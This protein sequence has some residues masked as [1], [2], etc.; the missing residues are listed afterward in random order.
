MH[1][2]ALPV[3]E[4]GKVASKVTQEASLC[5][6]DNLDGINRRRWGRLLN[7]EVTPVTPNGNSA[8]L[9]TIG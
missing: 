2:S 9:E 6:S 7:L 5:D 4:E 8:Y 3:L 1:S